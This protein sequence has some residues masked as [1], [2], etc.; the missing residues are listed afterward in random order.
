M[1]K[2]LWGR[3]CSILFLTMLLNCVVCPSSVL[4]FDS[5]RVV[6]LPVV[7]KT[8]YKNAILTDKLQEKIRSQFR[9]PRYD[10]VAAPASIIT[11]HDRASLEQLALDQKSDAV[12]L[13]TI[14]QLRHLL[15]S[16]LAGDEIIEDTFVR[17]SLLYFNKNSGQ[18]GLLKADRQETSVPRVDNGP[19]F[20]ALD[21]LEE[22]LNKL[23]PIFPRQFPGPRY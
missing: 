13:L 6:V 9:F 5:S 14:E 7:D 20:L 11:A 12:I 18:Y 3:Y 2:N 21:A 23:D 8:D 10:V 4:A 1:H 16:T 17:L 22:I 15:Y 19:T